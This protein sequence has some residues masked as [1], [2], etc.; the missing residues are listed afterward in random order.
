MSRFSVVLSTILCSVVASVC[1]AGNPLPTDP[2]PIPQGAY[3]ATTVEDRDH[4]T[5]ME[6]AGDYNRNLPNG[7]ANMA[8]RAV[9]A[10]EFY[11][12][13]PDNY[14]F[15]VVF[16]SF[17]FETGDATAFH[18]GVRNDVQG[19]G[20]PSY[21]NS[22]LYGSQSKLQGYIDMAAASRYQL[23][24]LSPNFNGV[25]GVLSHEVLHNWASFVHFTNE[26]GQ[27]DATL[28]GRG[29]S[30][31]NFFLDTDASVQYGHDWRDNGDGSFSAVSAR[32]F[33]SPLDLYL[34]GFYDKSQ[35]P[36]LT[37]LV[38][39]TDEY[40]ATDLPSPGAKVVATTRTVT[41]E[42]IIDHEG[43]RV[44]AVADAQKEFRFGFIYLVGPG[45]SPNQE[46]ING[47]G[48]VRRH[49]AERFAITTA[50]KGIAH[51]Y[52]QA[53][54]ATDLGEVDEVT[55]D[56]PISVD[57]VSV[58]EALDWLLAEKTPSHYWQDK[59]STRLRDTLVT[60]QSLR[61]LKAGYN[62]DDSVLQWLR[63]QTNINTDSLARLIAV[64]PEH[65]YRDELIARQN[66][67]GGWGLLPGYQSNPLDTALAMSVLVSTPSFNSTRS[68]QAV[69]YLLSQQNADD[70]WPSATGSA[71][72]V[73]TTSSVL[74]ALTSV[75]EAT[76]QTQLALGWLAAQATGDGG[77][78]DGVSSI[79]ETA[80]VLQVFSR[81]QQL[82]A[83]DSQSAVQFITHRQRTTGHW[84]GSVFTTALAVNALQAVN[85]P[86]VA[87]TSLE[88]DVAAPVDGERV[89]LKAVVV[90]DGIHLIENTQLQ[91]YLGDP[92]SGGTPINSAISIPP[93][94]AY[95][96]MVV[97]TYWDSFNLAG[98]QRVFAVADSAGILFERNE[99]DNSQSLTLN[100][101]AAPNEVELSTSSVDFLVTPEQP[102][103]LP[104]ELSLSASVR[105]L[106]NTSANDVVVQLSRN[107]QWVGQQVVDVPARGSSVINFVHSLTVAGEQKFVIAVDSSDAFEEA[108][109]S[110]NRA[111]HTITT[112]NSIDLSVTQSAID[113]PD[114][115]FLYQDVSFQVTLS[116]LGTV[117][118]PAAQ[119]AFSVQT[120][121]G[122]TELS[123]QNVNI[124][125]GQSVNREVIWRASVAGEAQFRVNID[126]D[127]VIVETN[128]TNNDVQKPIV[129]AARQGANASVNYRTMQFNPN[130]AL[131]A[132]DTLLSTKV[133]NS[134]TE[135]LN[136]VNVALYDGNPDS[137]GV[138][139]G[140]TVIIATLAVGEEAD[141]Q[142][143]WPDAAPA[144]DHDMYLVVDPDD[145]IVE[146]NEDD[147]ISFVDLQVHGLADL[148][149]SPASLTLLPAFPK[150]SEPAQLS[151]LIS[152]QGRQGA[153]NILVRVYVDASEVGDGYTVARIEGKAGASVSVPVM[154]SGRGSHSMR[155]VVDPDN[156]ILET[157]ITNNQTERSIQ[158][159]DGSFYI[160]ERYISPDGDGHK[161]STEFYFNLE[162]AGDVSVA[163][164]DK[165]NEEVF[166]STQEFTGVASGAVVWDGKHESGAVVADG[167][168]RFVVQYSDGAVAGESTV[169]IDTNRSSLTE[170]FGTEYELTRN[171]TCSIGELF[172]FIDSTDGWYNVDRSGSR[173]EPEGNL[174][175]PI[176]GP[177]DEF[178][179][180]TTLYQGHFDQDLGHVVF[181]DHRTRYPSGVYRAYNDGSGVSPVV[182]NNTTVN[183]DGV[184]YSFSVEQMREMVLSS[185]GQQVAMLL[186]EEN[187]EDVMQIWH[188]GADGKHLKFAYRE[189]YESDDYHFPTQVRFI[190]NNSAI[191]FYKY[192]WVSNIGRIWKIPI[193]VIS[194]KSLIM[195]I[196]FDDL[197]Y[198]R[199]DYDNEFI[200]ISLNH[201]GN[202]ALASFYGRV[203]ELYSY[204]EYVEQDRSLLLWLDFTTLESQW[205]SSRAAGHAWS[206][207]GRRFAFGDDESRSIKV[208]SETNEPIQSISL[209]KQLSEDAH[210][211]FVDI[212]DMPIIDGLYGR[213][214]RLSWNPDGSELAVVVSD[215]ITSF[216]KECAD[217]YECSAQQ[218]QQLGEVVTDLNGIYVVDLKD[219]TF[220]QVAELQVLPFI[221]EQ[222]GSYHFLTWDGTTWADRGALHY[223]KDFGT[224]SIDLSGHLPDADGE[225]KFR[226]QQ[227]G[228]EE[229]QVDA[230][231]IRGIDKIDSVV[232]L[233]DGTN[234]TDIVSRSDHRLAEVWQQTLEVRFTASA[235]V[236]PVVSMQAR[237]A[238]LSR[239]SVK[240]IDFPKQR[241]LVDGNNTINV[242]GEFSEQEKKSTYQFREIARPN[243]G[244]PSNYVTGYLGSDKS[245]L[246]A[247][248][249]FGV[250]NT[251]A[252]TEDWAAVEILTKD[253]WKR[254]EI[255][256]TDQHYG[257]VGVVTNALIPYE[258]KYY[259]FKIPLSQANAK[260]GDAINVRFSAYGSAGIIRDPYADELERNEHGALIGKSGLPYVTWAEDS[261]SWHP[262]SDRDR[263]LHWLQG[264]RSLLI[265]ENDFP[266]LIDIEDPPADSAALFYDHL[267][268]GDLL[269]VK[270][271]NKGGKLTFF[272]KEVSQSCSLSE[273]GNQ[274]S[275][276]FGD[277]RQFQSLLNLTVDVKALRSKAQGGIIIKGTAADKYFATWTLEYAYAEDPDNWLLISPPSSLTV[278][279]DQFT[280]WVPPEKGTF[281][282]RLT[283]TDLAGNTRADMKQVSVSDDVSITNVFRQPA[284]ISPN[285]DAVQD[286][287]E[288]HFKVLQPV[289]IAM[290]VFNEANEL[291]R[292]YEASFGSIGQDEML[293]WDGRNSNG[294]LV[295]DGVYRVVLQNY[296]FFVEL[297]NTAPQLSSYYLNGLIANK[298]GED[299]FC[300]TT[301]PTK[302][303]NIQID[304][305]LRYT[306]VDRN[307][308]EHA[309]QE[310]LSGANEWLNTNPSSLSRNEKT[311]VWFYRSSN[312]Y[313]RYAVYDY[314]VSA[315][316]K[317]GN[318]AYHHYG[319]AKRNQ[320]AFIKTQAVEPDSWVE[321]LE[322]IK[323][324]DGKSPAL[325]E[326]QD[327]DLKREVRNGEEDWVILETV[328][329]IQADTAA[330]EVIYK[331][332]DDTGDYAP[333]EV[334]F[335]IGGNDRK[336]R[337]TP[338]N[339]V[340]PTVLNNHF[341]S[342]FS[343]Q[344]TG[345]TGQNGYFIKYRITDSNNHVYTTAAV[346]LP[347]RLT[348]FGFLGGIKNRTE[349]SGDDKYLESYITAQLADVLK[350]SLFVTSEDDKR[351][352]T[353][354]LLDSYLPD[355]SRSRVATIDER[356]ARVFEFN[357]N[358]LVPCKKY[359]VRAVYELSD[360]QVVDVDQL[361]TS[362]CFEIEMY[363]QPVFPVQCDTPAD[364]TITFKIKVT[365]VSSGTTDNSALTV[366]TLALVNDDVEDVVANVNEPQ[367]S[368]EYS[369]PIDVSGLPQG[370]ALFRATV[371]AENGVTESKTFYVPIE[372]G[373]PQ[374]DILYPLPEQK[375]CAIS[376]KENNPD[377]E[378]YQ[379]RL[380]HAIGVE[381]DIQ[382]TETLFYRLQSVV[383]SQ[384]QPP[385]HCAGNSISGIFVCSDEDAQVPPQN[386]EVRYTKSPYAHDFKKDRFAGP[387]E[388]VADETEVSAKEVLIH[389]ITGRA[390]IQGTVGYI[391]YQQTGD[392]TLA[393]SA[394][395]WSGAKA[396][397]SVDFVVDAEVEGFDV[398]LG[399]V[400]GKISN[401][402]SPNGDG[403]QD[404]LAFDVSIDEFALLDVAVYW[405]YFDAK[406][407]EV[408]ELVST[409]YSDLQLDAGQHQL[410]W[411]GLLPSNEP[412]F[413]REYLLEVKA[414]DG[415]GIVAV[416]E[417]EV[418]V[419]KIQPALS[420]IYPKANDLIG[421]MIEMIG[422]VT[423]KNLES[424]RIWVLDVENDSK[425]LLH[426]STEP[427][428]Q[429][430]VDA[431]KLLAVWNTFGLVGLQQIIFEAQ[432]T[433]GNS[434]TVNE[435]INLETLTQLI[436]EHAITD[437]FISPNSDEQFDQAVARTRFE[438]DVSASFTVLDSSSA[439]VRHLVVDQEY[440]ASIN[441]IY[442]DGKDN[443]GDAVPDGQY[444]IRVNARSQVTSSL[445]QE[446]SASVIHDLEAPTVQVDNLTSSNIEL[447]GTN[448]I[449]GLINDAFFDS[450]RV[451]V[452]QTP[453]GGTTEQLEYSEFSTSTV[454]ATVP[455]S[456]L[457]E[458]GFYT[459][460]ILAMD[461]AGNT[462]Q[463]TASLLVDNT[464]PKITI[465]AP[466][467]DSLFTFADSPV[468]ITGQLLEDHIKHYSASVKPATSD[469]EP[470]VF[471]S[472]DTLPDNEQLAAWIVNDQADGDYLITV[473]AEDLAGLKGSASITVNID[474][475]LPAAAIDTPASMAYVLTPLS[476]TGTADDT[477]LL[478][479]ELAAGV[480]HV[481]QGAE[482]S[483][484]GLNNQSVSAGDLYS[485]SSLPDDGQYTLRLHVKD[486]A[487]N[488][489]MVY[490]FVI[491]DTTPPIAPVLD[492]VEVNKTESVINIQWQGVDV[493]DLNGYRVYRNGQALFSTPIVGTEFIDSQFSEGDYRYAVVAVDIAG[494][495]SEKSNTIDVAVD[496]TA[497]DVQITRPAE[498]LLVSGL[499]DIRG[500]AFSE[501]DFKQYRVLIGT[502]EDTL[503]VLAES[504]LALRGDLLT[505]W[506]TL[507]LP[508]SQPYLLRLEAEDVNNN[509]ANTQVSVTVDNTAPT[510]AINLSAVVNS[511]DV[512]VE[513]EFTGDDQDVA[514]YLLYRDAR[515]VNATGAVVGELLP[516]A[517]AQTQY[518]DSNR[519]DG[520]YEYTVF[521]IDRAGNIS[522]ASEAVS[523]TVNANLPHAQIVSIEDGHTFENNVY[524]L[525]ETVDEDVAFVEFT[526]R[527]VG[528]SSWI[529][530]GTDTLSPFEVTWDSTALA[531]ADYEVRAVATDT[532]NGVDDAPSV[533]TVSKVDLT[534]PLAVANMDIVTRGEQVTISWEANSSDS[535]VA[536]YRLYV[537]NLDEPASEPILVSDGITT[538][539]TVDTV[540]I[541]GELRY[542]VTVVDTSANESEYTFEQT[543]VFTPE[544]KGLFTPVITATQTVQGQTLVDADVS[545][546]IIGESDSQTVAVGSTDSEGEFLTVATL[547]SGLNTVRVNAVH[548]N[549]DAVSRSVEQQI[550][551]SAL[552]TQVTALSA[553]FD[554]E[555]NE[556]DLS[557]AANPVTESVI[558]YYTYRDEQLISQNL[559]AQA[560]EAYAT[561]RDQYA[562]RILEDD[563][564]EWWTRTP[565]T[566]VG[567]TLASPALLS[568]IEIDWNGNRNTA[569]AINLHARVDDERIVLLQSYEQLPSLEQIVLELDQP[570]LT[571]ELVIEFVAFNRSIIT[572]DYIR[573]NANVL[574]PEMTATDVPPDGYH[575][576][577][578]SAVNDDGLEGPKSDPASVAFGDVEAPDPVV[579]SVTENGPVLTINWS[580]SSAI[581]FDHYRVYRDDVVIATVT[582]PNHI[583]GPLVNATYRYHVRVV[584]TVG[585]VSEASNTV[586][587]T[588]AQPLLAPPVNVVAS[589]EQPQLHVT[590]SWEAA[591][592]STPVSYALFRRDTQN[593]TFV[594]I[595][596]VN[597]LTYLDETI[598]PSET[599][600]YHVRALDAVGN[601]SLPSADVTIEIIDSVA[602]E[603]P[604]IVNPTKAG[605]VFTTQ[606]NRTDVAGVAEAASNV[607]LLRNGS[608]VSLPA[609]TTAQTTITTVSGLIRD[610]ALSEHDQLA[611][612]GR[613]GFSSTNSD[614]VFLWSSEGWQQVTDSASDLGIDN[615]LAWVGDK[616]LFLL[617]DSFPLID[618]QTKERSY[619]P[620][621][622]PDEFDY[623][624]FIIG[625]IPETRRLLIETQISDNNVRLS[626]DVDTGSRNKFYYFDAWIVSPDNRFLI[627]HDYNNNALQISFYDIATGEIDVTSV[628]MDCCLWDISR[629][630]I[631]ED[632]QR[633]LIAYQKTDGN[634][635]VALVDR[636]DGSITDILTDLP[637][638]AGAVSWAFAE[639]GFVY[640]RT[641]DGTS[642]LIFHDLSSAEESVLYENG[643]GDKLSLPEIAFVDNTLLAINT[644]SYEYYSLTF[645]GWFEHNDILLT[646]GDNLFT[647]MA[648]DESGNISAASE[649]V[650]VIRNTEP[651]EDLAVLQTVTPKVTSVNHDVV[652]SVVVS[653]G[654]DESSDPT[655]I[656]LTLFQ[657]DNSEVE[658]L[659]SAVPALSSGLTYTVT[660]NFTADVAGQYIVVATVD[661]ENQLVE[662]SKA[663]NVSVSTVTVADNAQPVGTLDLNNS[664]RN[665][666]LF[667]SNETLNGVYQLMNAGEVFNGR[668]HL[669]VQDAAGFSVDVLARADI[670]NM[671]YSETVDL[672]YQWTTQHY[673]SGSY[674]IVGRLYDSSNEL[675]E[676]QEQ[677]F[678]IDE[679]LTLVS[680]VTT[681]AASY[682]AREDILIRAVVANQGGNTRYSGG[683]M[684]LQLLDAGLN[685]VFDYTDVLGELLPGEDSVINNIWNSQLSVPG[686]YQVNMTVLDNEQ[687]VQSSSSTQFEL[688][689]SQPTLSGEI[690]LG[691]VLPPK[692]SAV[693]A[694]YSIANLGNAQVD[695]ITLTAQ[696]VDPDTATV[697][698]VQTDN[699][700]L[701]LGQNLTFSGSFDSAS[702]SL[703]T[704]RV[705]IVASAIHNSINYVF[706]LAQQS[707]TVRDAT[708]PTVDILRPDVA[709]IYNSS[710][711][712]AEISV[713]DSDS[714][715]DWVQASINGSDW[716]TLTTDAVNT[717]RYVLNLNTL[718]D[719][720]QR[721]SVKSAD[722]AGN[723]SNEV[724]N[725][726]VIDNTLPDIAFSEVVNGRYYSTTVAPEFTVSDLH[727]KNFTA[728]LDG[729]PFVSGML[730]SGEGEHIVTVVA[731]DEAGNIARE[732]LLFGIDT[733]A[734][735]IT[736]S[737]VGD[738]GAYNYAVTPGI[739]ILDNNVVTTTITLNGNTYT[740]GTEISAEGQYQLLVHVEDIAANVS[741]KTVNF[742][743]DLT[744]PDA[745]VFTSHTNGQ[746]INVDTI[747]LIG[748]TEASA[749]VSLVHGS[750]NAVA[751]ADQS[752]VFVFNGVGVAVGEN[753]FNATVA[754]RAGNNS[755]ETSLTLQRAQ[756]QGAEMT[757]VI[758]KVSSRVLVW[759]PPVWDTYHPDC[760]LWNHQDHSPD[761]D[762]YAYDTEALH[763][764]LVETLEEDNT[765]YLV[766]R[767]EQ[768]FI[769]ALRSQH[770]N[771][772]VLAHLHASV[773]LPLE[774]DGETLL[775]LRGGIATGMGVALIAND[776]NNFGVWRDLLGV[777]LDNVLWDPNS[778][779]LFES[780]ATQSGSWSLVDKNA[781]DMDVCSAVSVG[782]VD[783]RCSEIFNERCNEAAMV[784]DRYADGDVAALAFN[785]VGIGSQADS[786][787]IVRNLLEF[788]RPDQVIV[789]PESLMEVTWNIEGLSAPVD[790]SF[791]QTLEADLIHDLAIGGQILSDT[792]AQWSASLHA[793]DSVS[794]TSLIKLPSALG[795]YDIN[796]ELFEGGTLLASDS[797]SLSVD[798]TEE[799]LVQSL[800]DKMQ[801][802]IENVEPEWR[803]NQYYWSLVFINYGVD[804]VKEDKYDFDYAI[805][806]LTVAI[807]K[808]NGTGD[809]EMVKEIGKLMRFYQRK[810]H[811]Y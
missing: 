594:L 199:L 22:E 522:D 758:D 476:V 36:P 416:R 206:V 74:M 470:A 510:S 715:V 525:A 725:D 131:E 145:A 49:F 170:A 315:R 34:M 737:G 712:R 625:F 494:W 78:G 645:A 488:E 277:Y 702:L 130:P 403:V 273:V 431:G 655:D 605:T 93:I 466:V 419:D 670:E 76:A 285:G 372:I 228:R 353:E 210:Q 243:T 355:G 322:R 417:L 151:V 458:E 362:S 617:P 501:T 375:V 414:T 338:D 719:G 793:S 365:D 634:Y 389:P 549:Y 386:E 68:S 701:P 557:W 212:T 84:E 72:T 632:S 317:A 358:D 602:P 63:S 394:Y 521:V 555:N 651:A 202:R 757:A 807:H 591:P 768:E 5:I 26:D 539:S 677:L 717:D 687:Q 552:P 631:S 58:D 751:I 55:S 308:D 637:E 172:D 241:Y 475:T 101:T 38:S 658:L 527:A 477:N 524:L 689:M 318:A 253:G 726:F 744:P 173:D 98:E 401:I 66:T 784:I 140:T 339:L 657:P 465:N 636:E 711:I 194:E 19:I 282:I 124:P 284:Y 626:I 448:T 134:G 1:Q 347:P 451:M 137:D 16:S 755:P 576:Y 647:V 748:T 473:N 457:L 742:V 792:Q 280:T 480:G 421:V 452:T 223:G 547:Y 48:D 296:E 574:T 29:D 545:L 226:I 577:Q 593:Q 216:L 595:N 227:I 762:H 183:V 180:F 700:S 597:D 297:D 209:P 343:R 169:S 520:E 324:A 661:P 454:I 33:F 348:Y 352:S 809:E 759:L 496:L 81:Y 385:S 560:I 255:N 615:E 108:N 15:L 262:R 489:R 600:T 387:L 484:L 45:E 406:G 731:E 21:D 439:I 133:S 564:F 562:Y 373:A 599:Y 18:V 245:Y 554:Q 612:V 158:I 379:R 222:G 235:S 718:T 306:V 328:E 648:V 41:I 548:P 149:V 204:R 469:D 665:N 185:D 580:T 503:Q 507:G 570:Y 753:A 123:V 667:F 690:T 739:D 382:S 397:T 736:V 295:A 138:Q 186:A 350:V 653:N 798:T 50:G 481:G 584:D 492:S 269:L 640:T 82:L 707:F 482:F 487:G 447:K 305:T 191:A 14:D 32:Y 239:Y 493:D 423:D 441:S 312:V 383:G 244:H 491:V 220:T 536:F 691:D 292:G 211:Q 794:F 85:L 377:V 288:M 121:E 800:R 436:S 628:P 249:D 639:R 533:Y 335:F 152:N 437:D 410:L 368:T 116:N 432:D 293:S 161:D 558:G 247:A 341:L 483:V 61:D 333:L 69:N 528:D 181:T 271:S 276:A 642:G 129:I 376:Y 57:P 789:T 364:P 598:L 23:N 272:T 777:K 70:G 128:E 534:P 302:N 734:A 573:L 660:G 567:L 710:R 611:I 608:V 31:W 620:N 193:G 351:Y 795:D 616:L 371:T 497:P 641:V 219:S 330:V 740:E 157:Q 117:D 274:N 464:P 107:D 572:V 167:D 187:N 196:N 513:W 727:L 681:D 62:V 601:S 430:D 801:Y 746:V 47:L 197:G 256:H 495:E 113:S 399:E 115:A 517:I 411:D 6:F 251:F 91:F 95:S 478:E 46:T 802:A 518:L 672:T 238:S 144:G 679:T 415:C 449:N 225:Y 811:E 309:V 589:L 571:D 413:D 136:N 37:L 201:H 205:L 756:S 638:H 175:G 289:N 346:Y 747:N 546:H 221:E 313:P 424:Y 214:E 369:L 434:V 20:L 7:D 656:V 192:D 765:F 135:V 781:V 356:E 609:L 532:F 299:G 688:R 674:K 298:N 643:Q 750:A 763:E 332:A 680:G 582:D 359:N 779:E 556:V 189:E 530:I 649:P 778:L 531:Y 290:Q 622:S 96:S 254:F 44:P 418:E 246:Y 179:Y 713:V 633:L 294:E 234:I 208:R 529:S 652:I 119:V 164:L 738:D 291:V 53:M 266:V 708:P 462:T 35:V 610:V 237:E 366:L 40:Q 43:P 248:L 698:Q 565:R 604:S 509:V 453:S 705:E 174:P 188:V 27:P 797:V 426:A 693:T 73:R 675:I 370:R 732:I 71:S 467:N 28:I 281:Y 217:K 259:E 307:L 569:A 155:V 515:L 720:E 511:D 624:I 264:S 143:V 64:L 412:V 741:E 200:N 650:Q 685:T 300:T 581:D 102:N 67:D 3:S 367:L 435:Q 400:N 320:L 596:A 592:A 566:M 165:R 349:S 460:Q 623:D 425:L 664:P 231:R 154:F 345:L 764:L 314:R 405:V 440:S 618:P 218:A 215:Y 83:I 8:A 808:L 773:G 735:S 59:N 279:D 461:K 126:G 516:Y 331:N 806:K 733:V 87:V 118:S 790:L 120:S 619:I 103:H 754:D 265:S 774:V 388:R 374:L 283:A 799:E 730:V 568:H 692:G 252:G 132:L 438:T 785:P 771:S 141:V 12:Q 224:D 258:H 443:N 160:T 603:P 380:L 2:F 782:A 550:K 203:S 195:E 323:N 168:Y 396:C 803:R 361:T 535:D 714:G 537:L 445:T 607:Y 775:E 500:T 11:Q 523:V 184:D 393:I 127:N 25:I 153:D 479:Y 683:T 340:D 125:A 156:T 4:I 745:P 354:R 392:A 104:S 780:G 682:S 182:I 471:Y 80:Q 337:I 110:D 148:A 783:Y 171:L 804:R 88:A 474:N 97:S 463:I 327:E 178:I 519:P 551:L 614:Q 621:F 506:D 9:V 553:E 442:W 721:L 342:V 787:Q 678:E 163:V 267:L 24:P 408:R 106:G 724:I 51:I 316:D 428:T 761:F 699:I 427:L 311:G 684:Q 150:Q 709:R 540:L 420:I 559:P 230:I 242:D 363:A 111:V 662:H 776:V 286:H 668:Y 586:E 770:Y 450:Y 490:Q 722:T 766:V 544:V 407:D 233:A 109:E 176:Y 304:E 444:T 325:Y 456:M 728:E 275:E 146:T 659:A 384:A 139:V 686:V 587:V 696:L 786:K 752:G 805:Y 796:A 508:E 287:L 635:A 75:N 646:T 669:E 644:D 538:S 563:G 240:P 326:K 268:S 703:K 381:A 588:V 541:D 697:L 502:S 606:A 319:D 54:P 360:G 729:A 229:A 336:K 310:S 90:N 56:D 261:W 716:M 142:I 357:A 468:L 663:N 788:I 250:D 99:S 92:Q 505:Q 422:T 177:D 512:S 590:L 767:S 94:A 60:Y 321:L 654:G 791:S 344:D 301:Q 627:A 575:D 198:D 433:A 543:E 723:T 270:P 65:S 673:F 390:I 749:I 579:I 89:R 706:D 112:Q 810:W 485:W 260:V 52:P 147:N 578:V 585:N 472:A 213:F 561:D 486:K 542:G 499:A 263:D 694:E 455:E 676:T 526:Y 114:Q 236:K 504:T 391:E 334:M 39:D 10:Q 378:E 329:T 402:F 86:N 429:N 159:Q 613:T 166:R 666:R 13:H 77:F 303:C 398:Q 514:G 695:D 395:N 257:T 207:D 30:H 671:A 772:V 42:Q 630:S 459:L 100:V 278:I 760:S 446:E 122:V 105:N 404:E 498:G 409:V 162:T 743:I 769:Q 232:N 79:H 583:D 704:Y 17:E 629:A 190:E